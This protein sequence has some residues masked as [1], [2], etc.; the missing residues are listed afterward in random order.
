[1]DIDSKLSLKDDLEGERWDGEYSR[2]LFAAIDFRPDLRSLRQQVEIA[3]AEYKGI[4]AG[5]TPNI[6]AFGSANYSSDEFLLNNTWLSGGIAIEIPIFD[7]GRSV[8]RMIRKDKEIAEAA[9][10]R[11]EA[12]DDAVLDVKTS[13]LKLKEASQQIPLAE[14]GENLARR[15]LEATQE[16]YSVGLVSS[17]DVLL[18]EDRLARARSTYFQA[19]YGY[20]TA[21]AR[22]KY[23]IGTDPAQFD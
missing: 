6:Y 14:K 1:M 22:L 23:A 12:V 15:N 7:G 16:Q 2:V 20:H 21:Y 19:L 13:Y 3:R 10:L 17:T 5:F 11:E 4:A 9:D 18:E 8:A